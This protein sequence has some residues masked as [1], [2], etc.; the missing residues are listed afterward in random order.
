MET[1]LA[2]AVD[3]MMAPAKI[4]CIVINKVNGVVFLF[5]VALFS[6]I[7]MKHIIRVSIES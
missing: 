4:I 2:R 1:E 3:V 6:K 5:L 7:N